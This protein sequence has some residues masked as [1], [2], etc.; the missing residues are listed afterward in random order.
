MGTFEI[1]SPPEAAPG[2][3]LSVVLEFIKC[4]EWDHQGKPWGSGKM[5]PLPKG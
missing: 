2:P 3:S 4:K 5:Q 1:L